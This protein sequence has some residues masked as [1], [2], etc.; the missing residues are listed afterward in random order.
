[1][2]SRLKACIDRRKR[3]YQTLQDLV[4]LEGE[5]LE[6]TPYEV[7]ADPHAELSLTRTVDGH[8]LAFSVE[9]YDRK[10]NGDL[11]VCIDADGLPTLLM[12]PSYRFSKRR[13][14]SVYY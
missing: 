2:Y 1:M 14:G 5:R 11:A 4:R 3:N 9:V 7:L 10:P 13:D 12:K 6:E 8:Q